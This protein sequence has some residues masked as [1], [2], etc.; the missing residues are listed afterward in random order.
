MGAPS[1]RV[2]CARVGFHGSVRQRF[3]PLHLILLLILFLLLGGVAVYR[4]DASANSLKPERPDCVHAGVRDRRGWNAA[5]LTPCPPIKDSGDAR[6]CDI[7][8][9]EVRRS[10]VEMGEAKQHRRNPQRPAPSD[11]PF[12]QILHPRAKEKFLWN[13][14]ENENIDPSRNHRE[15]QRVTMRMQKSQRQSE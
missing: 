7:P 13:G 14:N 3:L 11:A 1:L 5:M 2:F 10:F 9:V 12:K 8:P 15:P 6:Q 4:C